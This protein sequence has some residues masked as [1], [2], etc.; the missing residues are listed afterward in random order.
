MSTPRSLLFLVGLLTL[1]GL[2]LL[3]I[4]CKAGEQGP[5]AQHDHDHDHDHD[6]GHHHVAPHGGAL[7][8]LGSEFAH[9]EWVGDPATGRFTVY[10]LDGEA[11]GG[12]PIGDDELRFTVTEGGKSFPVVARA[13]ANPLSGE[14][15]GATS[16]FRGESPELVGKER[17]EVVLERITVR[18]V[19]FAAVSF[20]VPEGNEGH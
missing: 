20:A 12:V 10:V 7:A 14:E 8:V 16:E 17:F 1:S 4:G 13:A 5:A 19:E 18:G 15:V 2:A 11:V 3:P 6:H 9:I